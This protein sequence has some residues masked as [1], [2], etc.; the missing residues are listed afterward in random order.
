MTLS[1]TI[2]STRMVI[3]VVDVSAGDPPSR[4]DTCRVYIMLAVRVLLMENTPASDKQSVILR[5]QGNNS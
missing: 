4:A 5:E 3:G 2:A 1:G